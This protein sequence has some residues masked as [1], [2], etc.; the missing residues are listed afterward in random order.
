M[1]KE[2]LAQYGP[3]TV[4]VVDGDEIRDSSEIDEE[5]GGCAIHVDFPKLIPVNEIWLEDDVNEGERQFLIAS[6]IKR[7]TL[8]KQGVSKDKAY[9]EA[10]RFEKGLRKNS[11]RSSKDIR[12]SLYYAYDGVKV[13][14]VRGEVVRDKYKCDFIEGANQGA[15]SEPKDAY[16]RIPDE[17]WLESGLDPDE[18][19]YIMAHEFVERHLVK[20]LGYDIWKAYPIGAKIEWELRRRGPLSKEDAIPLAMSMLNGRRT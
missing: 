4:Y 15:Y 17:I 18:M 9:D 13:Y 2:Q 12:V 16:P 8:M 6:A 5:F 11:D 20:D 14:L 10:M 7:L 1:N 19:P 3:Y